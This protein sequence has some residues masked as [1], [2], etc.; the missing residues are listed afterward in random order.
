MPHEQAPSTHS[1]V[2]AT[3]PAHPGVAV[4]IVG[5]KLDFNLFP[6][7]Y[8]HASWLVQLGID[9]AES[10]T[11]VARSPLWL[12]SVSTALLRARRLEKCFDCDFHDTAKRLVL[13]DTATLVRIGGLVL[14]TLLREHLRRI[15]QRSQVQALHDCMGLEAHRF[16]LRWMGMVPSIPVPFADGAIHISPES[17][18]Q[19]SVAQL[20]AAVPAQATG[21]LERMRLRFPAHWT[22][23]DSRQPQLNEPQRSALMTLIIAVIADCAAQWSWLFAEQGPAAVRAPGDGGA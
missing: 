9:A 14:A 15:V 21:I 7:K 22:L 4:D 3:N 5:L 10:S 19:R 1:N 8:A 16:A 2:A 6:A 13:I 20:F 17:W 11:A 18:A 12:R 23:P